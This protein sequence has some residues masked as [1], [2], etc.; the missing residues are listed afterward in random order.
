MKGRKNK[1]P[2]SNFTWKVE[3]FWNSRP[4][5]YNGFQNKPEE[6]SDDGEGNTCK[7]MDWDKERAKEI[8]QKYVNKIKLL[9]VKIS[10]VCNE[11]SDFGEWSENRLMSRLC[12]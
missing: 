6:C 12:H 8:V 11:K 2:S 4:D 10:E 3:K 7:N 5:G 9:L 1:K